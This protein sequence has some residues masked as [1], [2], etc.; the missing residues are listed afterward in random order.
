M[1][2]N[3]KFL[4]FI[5]E[6]GNQ[7]QVKFLVFE[8]TFP[9][10]I[11]ALFFGFFCGNL[12]GTFLNFL[13]NFFSWDGFIIIATILTIEFINYLNYKNT[14]NITKLKKIV[15]QKSILFWNF[16]RFNQQPVIR[17]FNFY[18]IGL[19]LGFFTDAFKVGS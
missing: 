10:S 19:L 18:K 14:K 5:N 9:I 11:F 16:F 2:T 1:N 8:K 6:L 12:F 15:P 7:S 17:F 3:T 13:R 4:K